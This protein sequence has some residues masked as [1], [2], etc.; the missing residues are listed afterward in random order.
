MQSWKGGDV[1]NPSDVVVQGLKLP[2]QRI[3]TPVKDVLLTEAAEALA[4]DPSLVSDGSSN[5]TVA[6]PPQLQ[7]GDVAAQVS[8][9][10]YLFQ[11]DTTG[12]LCGNPLFD[13]KPPE[14]APEEL[15]QYPNSEYL[16]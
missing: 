5:V 6:L 2:L 11:D 15:V 1:A 9:G 16:P 3:F 13:L 4:A 7:W 12:L 10:G 14:D 8:R